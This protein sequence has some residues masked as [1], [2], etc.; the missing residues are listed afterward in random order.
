M[1]RRARAYATFACEWPYIM[2]YGLVCSGQDTTFPLGSSPFNARHI[3][4][5]H[6]LC[7]ACAYIHLTFIISCSDLSLHFVSSRRTSHPPPLLQPSPHH[8]Q[9]A[10]SEYCLGYG[11][12]AC[13]YTCVA[14]DVVSAA[15]K[16]YL[17]TTLMPDATAFFTSAIAPIYQP[18]SPLKSAW[19]S[20]GEGVTVRACVC[21]GGGRRMEGLRCGGT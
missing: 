20:C 12:A 6:P 2:L 8:R 9:P 10:C 13:R 21:G 18:A 3:S 1:A 11:C 4:S 16:T 14:E 19:S 5:H 7:C 15:K 17:K